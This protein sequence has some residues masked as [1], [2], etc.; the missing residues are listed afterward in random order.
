MEAWMFEGQK[1]TRSGMRLN[2]W[3]S[4]RS[5]K[6]SYGETAANSSKQRAASKECTFAF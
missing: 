2:I 6:P 4:L 1:R 3:T 5:E